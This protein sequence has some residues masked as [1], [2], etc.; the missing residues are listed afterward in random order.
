MDLQLEMNAN[1]E[2]K[3]ARFSIGG[4]GVMLTPPIGKDY[5]LFRVKLSATQ[6]IIGFKKFTTIGIGFAEEEDWNTNLPYTSDADAI[7]KHIIHNKGDESI[8]DVD[9]RKA[10]QLIQQAAIEYRNAEKRLQV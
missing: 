3:T 2:D 4:S 7:L 9:V 10:I 8:D 1:E 6:A 5:W